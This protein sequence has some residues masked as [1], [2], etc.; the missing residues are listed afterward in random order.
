MRYF[1]AFDA[2]LQIHEEGIS[3]VLCQVLPHLMHLKKR[4]RISI[5]TVACVFLFPSW[6]NIA[7]SS[8]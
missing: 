2:I 4:L 5:F 8:R 1:I 7:I 6:K 3:K